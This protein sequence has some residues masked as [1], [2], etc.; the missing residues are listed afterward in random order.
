V[1]SD[2][3]TRIEHKR[4]AQGDSPN[5]DGID[6]LSNA[7]ADGWRV[8]CENGGSEEDSRKEEAAKRE[9]IDMGTCKRFVRSG[10]GG[11]FKESDDVSTTL[12]VDRRK[13]AKAKVKRGQGDKGD[14]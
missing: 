8:R 10:A 9:L 5:G 7:I 4:H 11:Q 1:A 2:T 13:K 12:S 6:A 3:L 14:R